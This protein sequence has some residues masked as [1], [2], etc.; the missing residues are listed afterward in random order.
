MKKSVCRNHLYWMFLLCSRQRVT[1]NIYLIILWHRCYLYI[2]CKDDQLKPRDINLPELHIPAEEKVRTWIA[3]TQFWSLLSRSGGIPKASVNFD[4]LFWI[5]VKA[6]CLF[7]MS[8]HMK[9]SKCNSFNPK[10]KVSHSPPISLLMNVLFSWPLVF[11]IQRI[12]SEWA[13]FANSQGHICIP[14][15]KPES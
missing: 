3:T 12:K 2:H 11:H 14:W 15:S 13:E 7:L 1:F 6:N 5:D 9:P 4:K 8:S 10:M